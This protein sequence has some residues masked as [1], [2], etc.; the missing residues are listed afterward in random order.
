MRREWRELTSVLASRET[1]R[2]STRRPRRAVSYL[3]E[4]YRDQS[5]NR[6]FVRPIIRSRGRTAV[7]ANTHVS[8]QFR[9][10]RASHEGNSHDN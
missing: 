2:R 8:N 4:F 3:S 7:H 10:Y 6:S 9:A 1:Q 5:I